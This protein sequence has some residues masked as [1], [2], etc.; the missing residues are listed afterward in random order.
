MISWG[1]V[2]LNISVRNNGT[3]NEEKQRS[4]LLVH[5]LCMLSVMHGAT[6]VQLEVH[7]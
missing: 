2:S 5:V 6:E 1:I 4:Q 3:R 7:C